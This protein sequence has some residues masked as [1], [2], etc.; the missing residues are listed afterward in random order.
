MSR[1]CL[2]FIKYYSIRYNSFFDC[3]D[4]KINIISKII[5]K[6]SVRTPLHAIINSMPSVSRNSIIKV[7]NELITSIPQPEFSSREL[8][9]A[10]SIVQVDETSGTANV[11]PTVVVLL[12]IELMPSYCRN[13]R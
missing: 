7:I 12:I 3:F 9:V 4:L 1:G 8:G 11:S 13:E 2:S 6:Y 10:N 5:D